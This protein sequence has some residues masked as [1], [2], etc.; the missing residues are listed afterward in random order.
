MPMPIRSSK[1]MGSEVCHKGRAVCESVDVRADLLCPR[2]EE[3][4]EQD[5]GERAFE[6]PAQILIRTH[7]QI[8]VLNSPSCAVALPLV[9]FLCSSFITPSGAHWS[10]CKL[11]VCRVDG[12]VQ[13]GTAVLLSYC[14]TVIASSQSHAACLRA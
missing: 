8:S 4:Q 12:S 11:A 6:T 2:W 7:S 14:S 9:A 13:L 5:A 1:S 3:I 10:G